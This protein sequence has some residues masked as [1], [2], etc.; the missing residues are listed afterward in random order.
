MYSCQ[1]FYSSQGLVGSGQMHYGWNPIAEVKLS[2][3][4]SISFSLSWKKRRRNVCSS[5]MPQ[6]YVKTGNFV[7]LLSVNRMV[8]IAVFSLP[9]GPHFF[10]FSA[11]FQQ[12][13]VINKKCCTKKMCFWGIIQNITAFSGNK[14]HCFVSGTLQS[15]AEN[16]KIT[17]LLYIKHNNI[18]SY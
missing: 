16:G 11:L 14:S 10:S 5:R 15:K 4:N 8:F 17:L 6:Q 3:W 2:R 9:P 7:T 12:T 1:T 18:F 13:E